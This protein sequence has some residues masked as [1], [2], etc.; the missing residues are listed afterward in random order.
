MITRAPKTQEEYLITE[1]GSNSSPRV[2]IRD[3][4]RCIPRPMCWWD[5]TITLAV[6]GF[7]YTWPI[8]T[9]LLQHFSSWYQHI[10]SLCVRWRRG[11]VCRSTWSWFN[12]QKLE[13]GG[14]YSSLV[15]GRHE[16]PNFVWFLLFPFGRSIFS[17]DAKGKWRADA[18]M[19]LNC[20][21]VRWQFHDSLRR[22][23]YRSAVCEFKKRL[24]ACKFCL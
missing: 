4:L 16:K 13:C 5:A 7:G 14:S 17:E 3:I 8:F 1:E 15:L 10:I 24:I 19:S 12:L 11:C 9:D 2:S 18:R 23:C 20:V 21:V 22:F 6:E